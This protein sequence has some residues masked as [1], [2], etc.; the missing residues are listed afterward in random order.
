MRGRRVLAEPKQIAD[1]CA[2]SERERPTHGAK[3]ETEAEVAGKCFD[4][5]AEGRSVREIVR[6]LR[7]SPT[8]FVCYV[9]STEPAMPI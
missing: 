9:A 2:A 7:L 8:A 3:R 4:M 5:F 1:L 6:R